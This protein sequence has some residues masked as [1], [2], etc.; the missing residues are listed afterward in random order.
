[1]RKAGGRP[2]RPAAD[3]FQRSNF[4]SLARFILQHCTL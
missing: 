1:M 4:R 3:F 2:L